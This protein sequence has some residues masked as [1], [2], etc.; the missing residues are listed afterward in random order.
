LGGP[1]KIPVSETRTNLEGGISAGGADKAERR[2]APGAARP[3][4]VKRSRARGKTGRKE[5]PGMEIKSIDPNGL[6]D[7][8]HEE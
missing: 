5:E 7:G 8:P 2:G 1:D 6:M 3:L 4:A